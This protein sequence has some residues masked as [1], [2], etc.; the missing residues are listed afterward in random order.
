MS[1]PLTI[2]HKTTEHDRYQSPH[3]LSVVLDEDHPFKFVSCF[4]DNYLEQL[5]R[6]TV[7]TGSEVAAVC[8]DQSAATSSTVSLVCC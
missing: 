8:F 1:V 5:T 3:I 2:M 7:M 6:P 4:L